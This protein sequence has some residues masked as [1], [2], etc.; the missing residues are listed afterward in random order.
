MIGVA[1]TMR[2][3]QRA[4][5]RACAQRL[6]AANFNIC[7]EWDSMNVLTRFKNTNDKAVKDG[8]DSANNKGGQAE[9]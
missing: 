5:C 8:I 9:Q 3:T 7:G 6:R 4:L 1:R 2:G